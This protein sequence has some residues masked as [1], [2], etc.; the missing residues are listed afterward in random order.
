[1]ARYSR[2]EGPTAPF[3]ITATLTAIPGISI[4][5]YYDE[6]ELLIL[7]QAAIDQEQATTTEYRVDVF[8]DGV[9]ITSPAH[10]TQLGATAEET[11]TRIHLHPVTQGEHT[12]DLRIRGS[13]NVGDTVPAGGATLIVLQLPLWDSEADIIAL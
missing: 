9:S 8:V 4:T 6:G 1:M 7:A 10:L 2:R 11:L 12:I 13:G 3:E 5:R